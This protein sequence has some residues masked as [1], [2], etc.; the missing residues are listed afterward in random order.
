M[1]KLLLILV[2]ALLF[3]GNGFAQTLSGKITNATGKALQD[4]SVSLLADT[5]F[6]AAAI[7]DNGGRFHFTSVLVNGGSYSLRL[8]RIGYTAQ[9][10]TFIYPDTTGLQSLVLLTNP[11]TMK[12]VVVVSKKPLI[13]RRSDR[14]IVNVEDSYLANGRTGL[15]VLQHSPGLWVDPTGEIRIIGGQTVTVMIND[16]VQRMSPADLAN[17]LRSLRS[18]DINRIE[19]IPNPPAE[20]EASSTGGI[21]HI[22]LKK[23]RK[24]GFT[25]L[26]SAT[27][28][29]Q[30][31]R[32][33]RSAGSSIDY[34]ANRFYIT[35]G[36]NV[37]TDR[38]DYTGYTNVRYPDQTGL[39]S[40]VL[41]SNDNSRYA[42][43]LGVVYDLHKHHSLFA[44]AMITGSRMDQH[45]HSDLHYKLIGEDIN[46][47]ARS[48]W[49]RK[50]L[51]GSYTLNYNW[52]TDSLGSGLRII[53]DHTFSL[54]TEVNEVHSTYS[55]SQ[56]DRV[57]RTST[58][59]DTYINSGQ[60]DYT[61]MLK[62]TAVLRAGL[63]YVNTMRK[64][65]VIT[66]LLQS[67]EW[68]NDSLASDN[69][70]YT[71][72]LLMG[73]LT[74]EKTFGKTS[75]KTGLRGE[76]TFAEGYSVITGESIRRRYFSLFPSV[77]ISHVLND[78]S[79]SSVNI[80]YARRVRRPGYNDL[81]PYRLQVHDFTILAGNPDLVPQYAHS[82]RL[83]WVV[84]KNIS[85]GSY[86]QAVKNFM[87]QTAN[88]ID[89]NIIEYRSKNF[90]NSTDYGFFMEG[91]F[92]VKTWT[93]R[94]NMWFYRMV[95]E[96]EGVLH[97]RNSFS[98]QS[99]QV[100]T[101]KKKLE[102]DLLT[103]YSSPVLLANQRRASIFYTDIGFS[104][105]CINNRARIR[106]SATDLFNTFREKEKAE[107]D[108]TVIDFYQKRPT[109]TFGI[110][111]SYSFQSGKAFSK[112]KLDSNDSEEKSR[113]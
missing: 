107:F 16:V 106:I 20:Y 105:R 72:E 99:V 39:Y 59:S 71:E 5:S 109:R 22:I 18:E 87:A 29:I 100:I 91:S 47:E 38:S 83:A 51:Q 103:S 67:H 101:V 70:R 24:N 48:A 66:D 97:K 44:Q 34:K 11:Q 57:F 75:L 110:S 23:A 73:Y 82:F 60:A 32:S 74:Y 28:R 84:S 86:L 42:G 8:T 37:N 45:F 19:V 68:K 14:Y 64:N 81:N 52:K 4:V 65:K 89:S 26:A 69:F 90:P 17:F 3:T 12:E 35:G 40:N 50:P 63:K 92:S 85:A 79:G 7:T 98:V 113:L 41:R 6:R 2:L 61:K 88:R 33:F 46:G 62:K 9:T 54:K 1:N 15:E 10:F 13:T 31:K 112:K 78:K 53:L 102:I 96:I 43:R 111:F 94:T 95:N 108:N 56:R 76:H 36:I 25:G 58:P 93:S 49:M 80:S 21:I 27:Y 55:E 77:F 104:Y 30:G